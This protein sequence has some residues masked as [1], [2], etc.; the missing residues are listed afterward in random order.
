MPF[1]TKDLPPGTW[2]KI[3]AS[4]V[5]ACR[6]V[7]I[8]DVGKMWI[9]ASAVDVLPVSTDGAIPFGA[10]EGRSGET[11]VIDDFPHVGA[12][13]FVYA[14]APWGGAVSYSHA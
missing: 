10:G 12:T 3:T 2:V 11:P 7:H 8:A 5:T 4:A 6:Y 9:M 1:G 13:G 14:M